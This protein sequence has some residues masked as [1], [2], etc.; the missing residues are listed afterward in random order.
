MR[1]S[2]LVYFDTLIALRLARSKFGHIFYDLVSTLG[3]L[4]YMLL[5]G[6]K[7]HWH[8]AVLNGRHRAAASTPYTALVGATAS[9]YSASRLVTR[10]SIMEN[11][12][13]V[14]TP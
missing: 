5:C 4:L 1:L 6:C 3:L 8:V 2:I 9:A 11:I 10:P 14:L 12:E 7:N 13:L